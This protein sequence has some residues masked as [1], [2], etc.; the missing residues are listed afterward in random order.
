MLATISALLFVTLVAAV[1]VFQV[2]LVLGAPLGEF[3]LGGKYRGRLPAAIRLVPALSA[4]LLCGFAAVVVARAGLAFPELSGP[5]PV[6][7][8]LVVAYCA[9]GALANFFTPSQRE[10]AIWFPV[11]LLMLITSFIVAVR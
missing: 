3:T 8:W 6:L 9:V 11:V 5:A 2:A 1:T 7:I 10:R 4:L